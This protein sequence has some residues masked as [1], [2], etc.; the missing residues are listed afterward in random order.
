VVIA[1]V[2]PTESSDDSVPIKKLPTEFTD[3]R[4]EDNDGCFGGGAHVAD[5]VCL[6]ESNF[7]EASECPFDPSSMKRSQFNVVSGL[8]FREN[9][10][11]SPDVRVGSLT[12]RESH[13]IPQ[14]R[15][16]VCRRQSTDCVN[17]LL[18]EYFYVIRHV[19]LFALAECSSLFNEVILTRSESLN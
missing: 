11:V 7:D 4:P 1:E 13:M 16:A 3:E 5:K 12:L 6:L 17:Q 8:S 18:Y 19:S 2:S 15:E 14:P 10:D 9:Q